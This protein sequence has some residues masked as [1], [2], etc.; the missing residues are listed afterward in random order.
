M[1]QTGLVTSPGCHLHEP[2]AGHPERPARLAAIERRLAAV[3]LMSELDTAE[4]APAPRATLELSH[5]GE[6]VE[7]VEREVKGGASFVDSA[8]ANVGLASYD[9]ALLAAGGALLAVDRV[10]AG[11]WKN[12][13]VAV[14]PPGHHAEESRAMGFCLFN[15]VAV[16]ARH[17]QRTHGLKKVAILDWD[18]HHGNGTQHL[19]ERDP[20]VFYASLHQYPHYPGTGAAS[21]RGLGDGEG[22]VLNCP[23]A[24][25]TGDYEWLDAFETTVLPALDAF[26]PEFLLL[27]AGF[28]AHARDPLSATLVTEDAYERMTEQVLA[29][30]AETC[31]GRVVSVLEGGYDLEGLALSAEAHVRALSS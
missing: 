27:S 14:R 21:E 2:G 7:H 29:L 26:G 11:T 28:D 25:G 17:I 8:D 22:S 31:G 1:T 13:F 23:M 19:F 4:A 10:A 18:V 9:A 6:Y 12:A 15:N 3:G 24:P 30:A 5:P 16:A 20:D